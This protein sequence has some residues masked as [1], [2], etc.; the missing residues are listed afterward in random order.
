VER[1]EEKRREEKRREEKRR[2][3]KRREEKRR[4]EKRR[5]EKRREEKNELIKEIQNYG[6]KV[7]YVTKNANVLHAFIALLPAVRPEE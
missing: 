6:M 3:E 5:E 2:E 7:K 4:E 1:R